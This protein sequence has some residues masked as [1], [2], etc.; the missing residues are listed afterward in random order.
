LQL[1]HEKR[2]LHIK[3]TSR[4]Q[5]GS[6]SA[7]LYNHQPNHNHT[8]PICLRE[9]A[10]AGAVPIYIFS[11]TRPPFCGLHN[12]MLKPKAL[13]E[14]TKAVIFEA[15]LSR[16]EPSARYFG[17]LAL[18]ELRKMPSRVKTGCSSVGLAASPLQQ[19]QRQLTDCQIYYP[20]I[21][22]LTDIGCPLLAVG[23]PSSG[24]WS[25]LA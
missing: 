3:Q 21:P 14:P 23:R 11:L 13:G 15:T 8:P 22:P 1:Q 20:T 10:S 9:Y 19:N 16:P 24:E 7:P 5:T 17:L 12:S 4:W 6:K 18:S 25:R 2:C